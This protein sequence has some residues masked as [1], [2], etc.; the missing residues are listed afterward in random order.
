VRHIVCD[1]ID[2]LDESLHDQVDGCNNPPPKLTAPAACP[3]RRHAAVTGI[4]VLVIVGNT[5]SSVKR[6]LTRIAAESSPDIITI[7]VF[8]DLGELP[9]YS[10][11]LENRRTPASVVALRAAATQAHA[12]LIATNYRGRMPAM[13]HNAIDWLTRRWDQADLDDK[14]L[15]VIGRGAGCY[16][17]VWSHQPDDAAT[18]PGQRVIEP[19]T[20]AT[21]RDAVEMLVGEVNTGHAAS[22]SLQESNSATADLS[23]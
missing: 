15:A 12:V 23:R 14:P 17:G 13:V 9:Q 20:V 19:L 6:A 11:A 21:L 7:N 16:S 4:N 10:E 1:D 8:D 18:V 22:W 3:A 2:T 5:A